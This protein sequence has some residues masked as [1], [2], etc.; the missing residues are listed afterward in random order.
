MS[1]AAITN[2]NFNKIQFQYNSNFLTHTHTHWRTLRGSV[3]YGSQSE[4]A[5]C[6]TGCQPQ[7]QHCPLLL[8]A[9]S[10]LNVKLK[11][12]LPISCPWPLAPAPNIPSLYLSLLPP[13]S[14]VGKK[15]LA[16]VSRRVY[17]CVLNSYIHYHRI[18]FR[19]SL[20]L[21]LSVPPVRPWK[22]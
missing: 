15:Y 12:P 22:S 18:S 6:S 5:L 8:L 20:S 13:C 19:N 2:M 4:T 9:H 3:W 14:I 21:S 11:L 10:L 16:R 1:A 17:S 7:W